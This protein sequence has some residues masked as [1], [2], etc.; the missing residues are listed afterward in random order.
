MKPTLRLITG[1]G[2]NDPVNPNVLQMPLPGN[3]R[4]WGVEAKFVPTTFETVQWLADALMAADV[5]HMKAWGMVGWIIS[6]AEDGTDPVTAP[7]KAEY[8][9]VL[10]ALPVAPWAPRPLGRGTRRT[11]QSVQR[12]AGFASYRRL[13]GGAA[14][15]SIPV[16]AGAA[17]AAVSSTVSAVGPNWVRDAQLYITMI[18]GVSEN[19][20][21]EGPAG[22]Q[23]FC[24]FD[25]PTYGILVILQRGP[26]R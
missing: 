1:N 8:R 9:K 12:E 23:W 19:E 7:T 4:S 2:Y 21:R 5:P 15:L 11:S 20:S 22:Y 14:V 26:S 10:D 24:C 3:P 16:W 6:K 17:I 25:Q 13:T 18:M